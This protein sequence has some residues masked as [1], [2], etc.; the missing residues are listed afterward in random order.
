M[1]TAGIYNFRPKVAQP[2]KIFQQMRSDQEMPA[3]F[4]GG[5]QV[6]IQLGIPRDGSHQ[7]EYKQTM[8]KVKE[9][10]ISGNGIKTHYEHTQKIIMPKHMPRI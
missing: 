1:S 8:K 3:F 10:S 2:H 6:P 9:M 5:S 4:F 7:S